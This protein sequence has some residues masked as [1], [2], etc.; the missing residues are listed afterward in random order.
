MTSQRQRVARRFSHIVSAVVVALA[1]VLMASVAPA[2][3]VVDRIVA[4]V[5]DE[6]ITEYELEQ[7]AIPYLAQLGQTPEVLEDPAQR[8]EVLR[9]V[10]DEEIDT[11]LIRQE[12]DEQGVEV[13]ES[14]IDEWVSMTAQQQGMTKEQFQ[15]LIAQHGIDY[16]GEYREII[17][18]QLLRMQLMQQQARGGAV[19]ESAVEEAY[20]EQFGEPDGMQDEIEVR[21]ILVIPEQTEGGEDAAVQQIEQLRERIVSDGEDFAALADE[22]SQGPGAGDGGHIGTVTRGTLAESF[23]N[24]AFDQTVGEVSEPIVTEFGVHLIEVLDRQR[25]EDPEV[26]QR[27]EQ[28]RAQ[29]QEEQMQQQMESYIETLRTRAF[30]DVR[31]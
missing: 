2:A 18:N 5:G 7:A 19:S 6:I 9:E 16:E 8:D 11:M 25:I 26:E 13:A 30:V 17:R 31:Y 4:Q 27:K 22:Y 1:V 14:Q 21:H 24:A 29:L 15:Q 28:V 3:E 12:A 10:L 20:R 23:E